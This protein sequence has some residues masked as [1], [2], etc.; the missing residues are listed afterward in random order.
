ML[1]LDHRSVELGRPA[2]AEGAACFLILRDA[3]CCTLAIKPSLQNP[4]CGWPWAREALPYDFA[5][6]H[7]MSNLMRTSSPTISPPLSSALFQTMPKSFRSTLPSAV[8]P[9]RVLP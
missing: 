4:A 5:L 8:K 3:A 1:C 2:S 9:A 7:S 6:I